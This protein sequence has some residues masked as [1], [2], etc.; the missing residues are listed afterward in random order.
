MVKMSRREPH[1][2]LPPSHISHLRHEGRAMNTECRDPESRINAGREVWSFVPCSLLLVFES[3]H[4]ASLV[5]GMGGSIVDQKMARFVDGDC[6]GPIQLGC[7]AAAS[8]QRQGPVNYFKNKQ[9][10]G[11]KKKTKMRYPARAAHQRSAPVLRGTCTFPLQYT[12]RVLSATVTCH[13]VS[14]SV[15]ETHTPLPGPPRWNQQQERHP[16]SP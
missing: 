6:E 10:R 5:E 15:M 14:T 7:Q 1:Q 9:K 2:G 11:Y 4:R 8:K 12:R 13:R 16:L 3:A